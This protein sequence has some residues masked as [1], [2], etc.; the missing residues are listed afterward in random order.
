[1]ILRA[2]VR[3]VKKAEVNL[4]DSTRKKAADAIRQALNERLE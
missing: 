4:V 3:G 1:M 2:G